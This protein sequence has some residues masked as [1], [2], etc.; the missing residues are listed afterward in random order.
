MHGILHDLTIAAS[1]AK[2]FEAVTSPALLDQW[3]TSRAAGLPRLGETYELGF[4][5][6]C[7]W[8]ATVT[9]CTP[10]SSFELTMGRSDAD[11]QDTRVAFAVEPRGAGTALRFSHT[12]W[13]DANEHFRVSSFCWASYLRI[14]KRHLETGARVP[15]EERDQ[16]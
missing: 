9:R 2:V 6:E 10:G 7:T 3:W 1:A 12:G 5:P 14:L 8:Q 16:A 11:W 4:T 13:R 15:Y